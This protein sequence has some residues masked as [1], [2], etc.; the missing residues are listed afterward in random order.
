MNQPSFPLILVSI[1]DNSFEISRS[2]N[3]YSKIK[4]QALIDGSFFEGTYFFDGDGFKWTYRM[5]SERFKNTFINR[6]LANSFY[7]PS[8]DAKVIWTKQGSYELNEVKELICLCVDKDDD[9]YTQFVE[10]DFLKDAVNVSVTFNEVVKTLDK[11]V[12]EVNE[13][14]IW[15]E[16][17]DKGLN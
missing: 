10:A 2:I 4:A 8:L 13:N 14:T 17:A 6:L 3:D 11:Y 1:E 15:Q 16:Q 7:N 12:F 9:I 5:T